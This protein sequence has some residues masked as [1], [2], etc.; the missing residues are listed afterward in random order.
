MTEQPP[1]PDCGAPTDPVE[2]V[3]GGGWGGH[4]RVVIYQCPACGTKLERDADPSRQFN[5]AIG[6]L[7]ITL[8]ALALWRLPAP[9]NW[10]LGGL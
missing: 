10:V 2:M 1:C 7:E 4:G 9:A 3:T 6:L 5:S 8:G